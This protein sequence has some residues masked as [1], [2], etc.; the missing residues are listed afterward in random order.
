MLRPIVGRQV[1][2]D[3]VEEAPLHQIPQPFL[4]LLGILCPQRP[5][6]ICHGRQDAVMLP[7]ET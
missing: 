2:V 3:L 6:Y 7:G 5:G 4:N 1:T